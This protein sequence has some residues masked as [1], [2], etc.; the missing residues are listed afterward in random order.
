MKKA[1]DCRLSTLG[2]SALVRRSRR[3]VQHL[4]TAFVPHQLPE[5]AQQMSSSNRKQIQPL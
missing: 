4:L 2:S 3:Q 1:T 5:D